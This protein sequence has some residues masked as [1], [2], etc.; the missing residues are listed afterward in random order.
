MA[1]LT[2]ETMSVLAYHLCFVLANKTHEVL[3]VCVEYSRSEVIIR[4][5]KNFKWLYWGNLKCNILVFIRS[6]ALAL[7]IMY[8]Q[9]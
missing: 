7:A 2:H 6:D 3:Y 4:L 5:E 9:E 8:E 1:Q